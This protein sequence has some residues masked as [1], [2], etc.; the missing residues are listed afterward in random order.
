MSLLPKAM[1]FL[2]TF[3]TKG[4]PE[5]QRMRL[6]R[7][8]RFLPGNLGPRIAR[9]RPEV[10]V[11]PRGCPGEAPSLVPD[12]AWGSP[13]RSEP[14]GGRQMEPSHVSLW[15]LHKKLCSCISVCRRA[16][17]E[18]QHPHPRHRDPVN[19]EHECLA[20]LS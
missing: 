10:G 4:F 16:C 3:V 15:Q 20:T 18:K 5:E 12:G 19:P 2:L 11:P 1:A 13:P 14:V 9:A 8:V 7:L 17:S 6:M